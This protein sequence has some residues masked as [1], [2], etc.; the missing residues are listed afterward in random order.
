METIDRFI[1]SPEFNYIP[2]LD[3]GK[4]QPAMLER[5]ESG[6]LHPMIHSACGLEFGILGQ[7]AEGW[8]ALCD[9]VYSE[10]LTPSC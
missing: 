3:A 1:F 9:N 4:K 7:L 8:S 5:F 2:N 6:L 10:S